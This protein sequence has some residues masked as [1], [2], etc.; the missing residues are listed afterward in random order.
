M[1][2]PHYNGTIVESRPPTKT[3]YEMKGGIASEIVISECVTIDQ[4]FPPVLQS[5]FL[6]PDPGPLFNQLLETGDQIPLWGERR[7]RPG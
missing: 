1:T 6:G 7:G 2:T 5:L 3:S 4:L